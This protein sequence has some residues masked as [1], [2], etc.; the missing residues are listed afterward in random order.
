MN[1]QPDKHG[2]APAAKRVRDPRLDFFRGLGMF[3]ILIA[4]VR[5]NGWANWIPARFGFSD[6]ADM[7]VFCSGMA[8]AVAFGRLFVEAGWFQGAARILFRI[9]QVYWAHIGSFLAVA[10]VLLTADSWL[11][12]DRYINGEIPLGDILANARERLPEL[13]TLHYTPPY[14]DILPMYLAIL[15]MIPV[16]MWLARINRWLVAAFMLAC[17]IGANFFHLNFVGDPR[18]GQGWYFNPFG[19][20]IIFF[21]GFAFMRGWIPVP[22]VNRWLVT[23]SLL[24]VIVALPISC[25]GGYSCYA[26]YGNF[27]ALAG[28]Q[29]HLREWW[30][31]KTNYGPLRYLHFMATV[32]LAYVLA[33][34]RGKNL[35]GPV[36]EITLQV[37][38]QTLAVFLTGLVA[39]QI[40]GIVLDLIGRNVWTTA[41]VNLAGFAVLIAATRIVGWF[42][43]PPWRGKPASAP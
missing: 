27:P 22:P 35:K 8:S 6:A 31:E 26:G 32:Y 14:I 7:F 4:H 19:W 36:A 39:A 21:T 1:I 17:W 34:E 33:G 12:S 3:I 13:L 15:A 20:Q 30:T 11:G 40:M 23:A 10:L 25:Q 2:A 9:W 24:M 16:V 5:A 29:D 41:L 28:I 42:K 37:G 43:R 38:Q 18:T